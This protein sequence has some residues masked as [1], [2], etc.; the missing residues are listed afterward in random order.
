M[1]VFDDY[2]HMLAAIDAVVICVPNDMHAQFA[3]EAM[4]AGRHVLL[5]Y[6]LATNLEDA[7]RLRSV[8]I[9][10]K[11]VLMT[12]NTIIHESPFAYIEQHKDRMGDLVSAASRTAFYSKEISQGWFFDRQRLGPV[13]AALHYHHIEYYKHLLGDPAWVLGCD[14]SAVDPASGNYGSF[15]GGTLVMGHGAR[16]TSCIQWYL[17]AAGSGLARTMCLTGTRCAL[18][19]I[20]LGNGQMQARWEDQ[21]ASSTELIDESW[22]IEGSCRDFV[23][24]I[25]GQIDYKKRLSDDTQTLRIALAA[26]DSAKGGRMVHLD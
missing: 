12:G 9:A 23:L 20:S 19:L 21:S 18:T 25:R 16:K 24:A 14:E 7:A 13:H 3:T 17:G 6:P 1:K 5:E 22:G 10:Y 4:R 11:C 15:V 2:R 26:K 8:A